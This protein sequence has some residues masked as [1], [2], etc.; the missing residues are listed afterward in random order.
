MNQFTTNSS[1]QV[2]E[3]LCLTLYMKY[4]YKK[5]DLPM[6]PI[7]LS[8]LSFSYF[9]ALFVCHI[10][11]STLMNCHWG[12]N[13]PTSNGSV[14]NRLFHE[15]SDLNQLGTVKIVVITIGINKKAPKF[16]SLRQVSISN[17]S[18]DKCWHSEFSNDNFMS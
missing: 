17:W 8:S 13:C 11:H 10:S 18:V 6:E 7:S 16:V 3:N 1:F 15:P 9:Q 2:S 14:Q 12:Q 4:E 5:A